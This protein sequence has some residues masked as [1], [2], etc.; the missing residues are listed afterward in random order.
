MKAFPKEEVEKI[1]LEILLQISKEENASSSLASESMDIMQHPIDNMIFS[2]VIMT[3][4]RPTIFDM[5]ESIL[6]IDVFNYIQAGYD[7]YNDCK[8]YPFN[9]DLE[10]HFLNVDEE[11]KS[12]P[13]F[14]HSQMEF[15]LS[16]FVNAYFAYE[17]LEKKYPELMKRM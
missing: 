8:E 12:L 17:E 15:A 11:D 16:Q 7:I 1:V 4:L 10:K 5:R 2:G 9:A 3:K 13:E 6:K 14:N